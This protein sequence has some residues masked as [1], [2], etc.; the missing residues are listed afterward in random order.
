MSCRVRE[1]A[2][3]LRADRVPGLPA[4]TNPRL[5]ETPYPVSDN[6][7]I[8]AERFARFFTR[9]SNERRHEEATSA[10]LPGMNVAQDH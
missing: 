1:L 6:G 7:A 8:Q 9:A 3:P 2:A 10:H 5:P 4:P